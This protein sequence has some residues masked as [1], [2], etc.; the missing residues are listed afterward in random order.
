MASELPA[1]DEAQPISPAFH[2][3]VSSIGHNL[4]SCCCFTRESHPLISSAYRIAPACS[5]LKNKPMR[6]SIVENVILAPRPSFGRSRCNMEKPNERANKQIGIC[7][8]TSHLE[9]RLSRMLSAIRSSTT[10]SQVL[11]QIGR[12]CLSSTSGRHSLR[13]ATEYWPR[14]PR[15]VSQRRWRGGLLQ[16]TSG[17]TVISRQSVTGTGQR[18]ISTEIHGKVQ[19]LAPAKCTWT[20]GAFFFSLEII[21]KEEVV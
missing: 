14:F 9:Q 11:R 8:C 2:L 13:S 12:T 6:Y 3:H 18:W 20:L 4:Y 7:L 19:F 16:C 21:I 5:T 1:G 15:N 10:M 17:R